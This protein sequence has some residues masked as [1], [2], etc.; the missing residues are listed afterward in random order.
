MQPTTTL[1]LLDRAR[2]G[3]EDAMTLLFERYRRRLCVLTRFKLGPEWRG[4]L[5][6]DDLV[7][8]TL[9]RAYRD[10]SRFSYRDP[11]SFMHW[12]SS[13][14]DHVIADTVRYQGRDRRHAEEMIRLRSVGNPG[15]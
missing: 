4:K 9:L 7:Q 8:E 14:A 6:V 15:G 2:G 1:D 13:I 12:L 3:A 5:D 11:G 10:L